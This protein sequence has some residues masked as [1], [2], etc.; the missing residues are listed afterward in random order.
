ME[1]KLVVLFFFFES[2]KKQTFMSS[3]NWK[4]VF[5]LVIGFKDEKQNRE[6][7]LSS[8]DPVFL[9]ASP[10]Q[11]AGKVSRIHDAHR[12]LDF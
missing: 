4:V 1:A 9:G 12:F 5:P 8:F 7:G 11:K 6:L 10:Q 3:M 2:L